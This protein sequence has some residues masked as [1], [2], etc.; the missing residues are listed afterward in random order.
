MYR[1]ARRRAKRPGCSG[2]AFLLKAFSRVK[3]LV[4]Q[5]EA[6]GVSIPAVSVSLATTLPML[7]VTSIDRTTVLPNGVYLSVL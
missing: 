3:L 7:P 5:I 4:Q 6:R 2:W 1:I